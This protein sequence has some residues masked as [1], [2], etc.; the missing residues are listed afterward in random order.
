MIE[1]H[2]ID[3][4]NIINALTLM[5]NV[6]CFDDLLRTSEVMTPFLMSDR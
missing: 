3:Q 6:I 1:D 2:P 5:N 4:G